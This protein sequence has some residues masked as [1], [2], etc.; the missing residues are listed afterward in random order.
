MIRLFAIVF[1]IAALAAVAA[2]Q[3][4]QAPAKAEAPSIGGVLDR[5]LSG[6]E[7]EVVEAADAMPEDKY[8]FAP[9]NGEFKGVMNF[10]QQVTHIADMNFAIFSAMLGEQAPKKPEA[11]TKADILKYLRDSSALGHRAMQSINAQNVVAD[12]KS[13]FGNGQV[14]RLAL[15][16]LVVGHCFDHYGQMVEYLRMNGIIPPASR[17]K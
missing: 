3:A 5:S 14:P 2:A 17:P 8:S 15:A 11:K 1:L 4:Q 9:T 7:R 13:P 16:N 10:G 6:V 12:V